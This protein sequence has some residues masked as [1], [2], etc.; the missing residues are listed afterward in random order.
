MS[1]A[2]D[3]VTFVPIRSVTCVPDHEVMTTSFTACAPDH[4]V[5]T[6]SWSGTHVTITRI[7]QAFTAF[8][9]CVAASGRVTGREF[10]REFDYDNDRSE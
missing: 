3:H 10:Y 4:E 7:H 1:H 5:M 2:P 6:T 8:T 9:A